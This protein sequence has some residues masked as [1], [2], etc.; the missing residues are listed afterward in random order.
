MSGFVGVVGGDGMGHGHGDVE[1]V[2]VRSL[3]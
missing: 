2:L 3:E 1:C